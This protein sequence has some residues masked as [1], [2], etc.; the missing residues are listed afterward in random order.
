MPSKPSD[1]SLILRISVVVERQTQLSSA[2]H[3]YS[4]ACMPTC[5]KVQR[6]SRGLYIH[7]KLCKIFSHQGHANQNYTEIPS[8]PI[9]M[10]I[11]KKSKQKHIAESGECK[12]EK[13]RNTGAAM[14][15]IG[16]EPSR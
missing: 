16:A 7:E 1:L 14:L 5:N 11:M 10:V 9:G 12:G 4:V 8:C 2:S 15:E 6:S 3:M 13:V